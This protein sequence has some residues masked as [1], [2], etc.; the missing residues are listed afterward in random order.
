MGGTSGGIR[1]QDPLMDAEPVG[2]GAGRLKTGLQ[3]FRVGAMIVLV[4]YS[5]ESDPPSRSAYMVSLA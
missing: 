5:L 2:A 1:S 4:R 3:E